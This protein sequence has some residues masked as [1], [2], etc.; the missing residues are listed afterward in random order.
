MCGPDSHSDKK[1]QNSCV[2][3][4]LKQLFEC[5]SVVNTFSEFLFKSDICSTS[6]AGRHDFFCSYIL[7]VEGYGVFLKHFTVGLTLHWDV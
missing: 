6:Q 7:E 3:E 2:W 1:V 4:P 5:L